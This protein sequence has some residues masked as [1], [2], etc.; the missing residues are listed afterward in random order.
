MSLGD[1]PSVAEL[2]AM[3]RR[4]DLGGGDLTARLLDRPEAPARFHLLGKQR[5]VFAGREITPAVLG[6]YD[7]TIEIDWT[8]HAVDGGIMSAV[9][10]HL[11]TLRG[12]LVS[13]LAA[14][15]VLLNFAQRLCGIAT[16]TRRFVDAV[17]GTGALIFDTRK[18]V[19]GWRSLEKYAVR[20]GGGNKHR[21]GLFDAVLIKNN[22]LTGTSLPRL[23]ATV[24]DMLNRLD[25]QKP[26]VFI[27]VEARSVEQVAELFAVVGIDA[28]LLDNFTVD[29]LRRAVELRDNYGLR[30]KVALEASGGIT[31]EIVGAVARTGVER[32]SVGAI[33]HSA[34]ALDLSLERI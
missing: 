6:A 33:T 9:P 31:L 2:I 24:F 17:A 32:I 4:E 30:G 5:G 8:E 20:C 12:P 19:P 3:A 34:P 1:D 21:T 25:G 27:E 16:H 18:T 23:A 22:H 15:R 7:S 10:T 11:A 28:I 13:L 26:P 29:E 14:E